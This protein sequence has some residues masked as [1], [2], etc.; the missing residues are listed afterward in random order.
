MRL[1]G[2]GLGIVIVLSTALSST[3]AQTAP[4]R[5]GNVRRTYLSRQRPIADQLRPDDE[6]VEFIQDHEEPAV[7]SRPLTT[8]QGLSLALERSHE[9]AVAELQSAVGR[10]VDNGRW[11]RTLLQFRVIETLTSSQPESSGTV[12]SFEIA[13]GEVMLEKVLVRVGDPIP[14]EAGRRY[15]LFLN[16][17][18][19][20]L[21]L[22]VTSQIGGA[23]PLLV[24]GN[25][26]RG[27]PQK[28]A[29]LSG[30]TLA[31][32]RLAAK[33]PRRRK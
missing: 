27:F 6:I 30:L 9:V 25:V 13:G 24:D 7:P 21:T 5:Q 2:S 26:L 1:R 3:E 10:L 8:K 29:D 22:D 4:E 33:E 12:R 14:Y 28:S 16:V 11:V 20:P 19:T 15:V 17:S 18:R 32:V 23:F 31:E